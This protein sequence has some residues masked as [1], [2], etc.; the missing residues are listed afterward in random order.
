MAIE[1]TNKIKVYEVNGKEAFGTGIQLNSHWNLSNRV[2]IIIRGMEYTVIAED[3]S[4][5]IENATNK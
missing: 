4:N 5:A 1:V 3:L 2:V